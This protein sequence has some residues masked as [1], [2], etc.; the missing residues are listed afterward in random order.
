MSSFI[1]STHVTAFTLSG[2]SSKAGTLRTKHLLSS[3]TLVQL[4]NDVF[5]E[6]MD[7]IPTGNNGPN[8]VLVAGFESFN[9]DL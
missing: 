2:P 4:G 8:I 5:H 6:K 7:E 1:S 9:K 3:S